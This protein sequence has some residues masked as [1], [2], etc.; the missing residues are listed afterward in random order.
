MR[1]QG[2]NWL[3]QHR[4]QLQEAFLSLEILFLHAPIPYHQLTELSTA[5]WPFTGAEKDHLQSFSLTV[6]SFPKV[7]S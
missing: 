3:T 5:C 7:Y 6:P 1:Q 4:L 2:R